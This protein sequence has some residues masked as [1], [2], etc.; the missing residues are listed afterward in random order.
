MKTILLMRHSIPEK[1]DCPT[2]LI[3]LST[4]GIQAVQDYAKQSL[5]HT[6]ERVYSSSY[7]RA[8]Q[9][10]EAFDEDVHII[11][12]LHERI[13]GSGKED[14]WLR[15]YQ[16]HDYKNVDGESLNEVRVRMKK[17]MDMIL[18]EMEED[19]IALVVSHATAICSYLMNMCDVAVVDETAKIRKVTWLGR[20]IVCDRFQPLDLFVLCFEGK[21]C[22][23]ISFVRH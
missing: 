11:D 7:L 13:C 17:T 9:T 19:T 1:A 10:A 8:K 14:I 3:P 5:F 18:D 6:V 21:Q 16:D 15:Q 2:H 23:D 4:A 12:D 20:K 22:T